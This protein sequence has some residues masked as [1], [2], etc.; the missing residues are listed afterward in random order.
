MFTNIPYTGTIPP[1]DPEP[2]DEPYFTAKV[3]GADVDYSDDTTVITS[4]IDEVVYTN[5]LGS[6]TNSLASITLNLHGIQNPG[7]Y[8]I[9]SSMLDDAN[10]SWNSAEGNSYP[11][12]S[13]ILTISSNQGGWIIGTFSFVGVGEEG[14]L[15]PIT[16]GTFKVEN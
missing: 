16:N 6:D 13:G 15:I 5:I 12:E 7:T 8:E 1:V 4:T 9:G 11:A 3:D 2:S 10:A 14:D